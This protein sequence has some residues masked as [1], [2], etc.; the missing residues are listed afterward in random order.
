MKRAVKGKAR[1]G[2]AQAGVFRRRKNFKRLRRMKSSPYD[3]GYRNGFRAGREGGLPYG[4]ETGVIA[5]RQPFEG[6]SIVIPTYNQCELLRQCIESIKQYTPERHEII[7][8]DNASTDGTADYLKS[9]TGQLR[10]RINK[11]NAGFSGGVNQGLK[12]ACGTTLMVLNNDTVVT[13]GWLGNLQKCLQSDERFGLVGPVTN[14]ISGEQLVATSY[15]N[16]AEMHRFAETFNQSDP[17]KWQKTARITGFCLLFRRELFER[18]GFFDEGFEIGNCEDDDFCLRVK[19]LG[20]QLV[21]ARDTF[22]HHV[23]SVSMKALDSNMGA[24]YEKNQQFYG[25]KWGSV[26][27]INAEADAQ[28]APRRMV[29]YYPNGVTVKGNNGALYWLR[30]GIR[31]PVT[32]AEQVK[33]PVTRLSHVDLRGCPVGGA[34]HADE[35]NRSAGDAPDYYGYRDGTLLQAEEGRTFLLEQG[36]VRRV[37]SGQALASWGYERR[38]VVQVDGHLLGALPA[39]LPILAPVVLQAD[40]L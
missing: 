15:P 10:Y 39:G 29:Q 35:L 7:V 36:K 9:M 34:V 26:P 19:L 6:T 24:V 38:P 13:K 23:G 16:I 14:Y 5:F 25:R 40:N 18:V 37:I 27:E 3:R 22:I 20:A 2:R 32:A 8:I 31:H 4:F 33:L 17:Q 28:T 1:A 21:I 30:D 11:T 12:M